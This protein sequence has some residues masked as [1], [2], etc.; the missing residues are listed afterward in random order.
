MTFA[1]WNR[2]STWM[3]TGVLL[4]NVVAA[5]AHVAAAHPRSA[6]A[7]AA[8][9]RGGAALAAKAAALPVETLPVA[10]IHPALPARRVALDRVAPVCL[11]WGP[12]GELAD[13]ETMASRL[14]LDPRSY[15]VF[16]SEV[17]SAAEYLVTVLVPG[18]PA[19][20]D[21]AVGALAGHHVDSYLLERGAQHCVLAAGVFS[22][23]QRAESQ[24]RRLDELGYRAQVKPLN[25]SREAYH[26]LA[27]IPADSDPEVPAVAACD[28]I[29]PLEQFL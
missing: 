6:H 12:F 10:P 11:A 18:P 3:L 8:E 1:D 9:R 4:A 22:T 24:R 15:E 17:R 26:L 23:P 16:Q 19:V 14:R 20:A 29:A 27:R 28:D 5:A 13:A 7:S 2:P 25:R 21:G